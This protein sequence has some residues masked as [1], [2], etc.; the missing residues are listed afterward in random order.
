MMPRPHTVFVDDPVKPNIPQRSATMDNKTINSPK[1]PPRVHSHRSFDDPSRPQLRRVFKSTNQ[2]TGFWGAN[3][4]L[5]AKLRKQNS[6]PEVH[7]NPT[8]QDEDSFESDSNESLLNRPV[9]P[10]PL[11]TLDRGRQRPVP[12]PRL[13]QT[14]HRLSS[15]QSAGNVYTLEPTDFRNLN[16]KFFRSTPAPLPVHFW[17]A[18]GPCPVSLCWDI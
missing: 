11:P 9:V 12:I 15:S 10:P 18:S 3:D 1:I 17:S 14:N 13:A 8:F 6:I 7:E 5:K 2:M 4:D 16:G